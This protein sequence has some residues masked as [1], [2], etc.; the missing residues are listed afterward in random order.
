MDQIGE[1]VETALTLLANA[2]T[3]VSAVR[4]T[5]ILEDYNKELVPFVAAKE[6]DWTSGAPRL[7]RPNFLKEATDY[8]QQ[9]Q[10]LRKAKE[11][12][13]F[14]QAPLCNQQGGSRPKQSWRHPLY[15]RPGGGTKKTYP[16]RKRS[17]P[18]K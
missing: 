10:L 18:K 3:Q 11:K 2:S 17:A 8:L 7:F 14:Q 6:R 1:A 16:T 12:P 9:L 5:K 13:V 4:R 15:S